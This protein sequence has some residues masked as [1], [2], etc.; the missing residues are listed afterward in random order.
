MVK[1]FHVNV[2][3]GETGKCTASILK[4]PYGGNLGTENHSWASAEDKK[5]FHRKF[6]EESELSNSEDKEEHINTLSLRWSP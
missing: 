2:D 1:K 4:C 6:H 3:T 5:A